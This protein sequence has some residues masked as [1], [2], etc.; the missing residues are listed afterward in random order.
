VKV[1]YYPRMNLQDTPENK[2]A[3]ETLIR[4]LRPS[5]VVLCGP[6]ACGKSMF[7]RRHFRATQ[8]ISSDW[9]RACVSDDDRDQR[10][11]A[12]AFA[13]VHFLIEQRLRLNRLCVV[14]STALTTAARKELLDVARKYSVPATLVVFDV[15]LETCIERDK[16]RERSVGRAVVERHYQ[17]FEQT[18]ESMHQEGFDEVIEIPQA[19]LDQIRVEILFRPIARPAQRSHHLEHPSERAARIRSSQAGGGPP[20]VSAATHPQPE[21]PRPGFQGHEAARTPPKKPA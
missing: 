8:V 2:K 6:A 16:A 3:G 4:L 9:A 11:N 19:G 14:D 10:C 17:A 15:P 13:L 1:Q 5:V 7:A 12:E 18:R 21:K 20:S